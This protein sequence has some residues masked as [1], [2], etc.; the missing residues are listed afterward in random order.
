MDGG[1]LG[2]E[3]KG[4]RRA[5]GEGKGAGTTLICGSTGGV[6]GRTK[7]GRRLQALWLVDREECLVGSVAKS[8]R[9]KWWLLIWSEGDP[10]EEGSWSGGGGW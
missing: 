5:E 7:V 8:R 2:A 10:E 6:A 4:E 9:G 1:W 3:T